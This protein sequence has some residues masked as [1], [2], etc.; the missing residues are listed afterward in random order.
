MCS[1]VALVGE[2]IEVIIE[3]KMKNEEAA[4]AWFA[5]YLPAGVYL[6]RSTWSDKQCNN[7]MLSGHVCPDY[8]AEMNW[9]RD[10]QGGQIHWN[11]G[12]RANGLHFAFFLPSSLYLLWPR[13]AFLELRNDNEGPAK[14]PKRLW[15]DTKKAQLIFINSP[16]QEMS[17]S[18][19]S[20]THS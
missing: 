9:T 16:P 3:M 2:A 13:F 11:R 20:L 5:S 10:N 14:Q 7:L 4:F 8:T 17:I 1:S 15:N 18:S 19:Y 6:L 12:T